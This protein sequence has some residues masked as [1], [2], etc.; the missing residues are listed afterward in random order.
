MIRRLHI[1]NFKAWRDTKSLKFA[2][3][4]VLFGAN[5]SGKSSINHLLMMLRQTVRST[6]RNSVL[7]LGDPESPVQLG[8][9][10][11]LL[12]EHDMARELQ[13]SIEWTLPTQMT[14]RDPHS[15]NRYAGNAIRFD[16]AMRQ[17]PGGRTLQSQGFTYQLLQDEDLS[18]GITFERDAKRSDRWRINDKNYK[19][20]RT[21]GRAWELPKPVQFYGF[22]NEASVYFQNSAFLADL[23]LAFEGLLEGMSY[24]GPLRDPPARLYLWSGTIPED[25]GWRGESTVQAILAGASRRFNWRAKART[26]SLEQVVGSWLSRLNLAASFEVAEIAPERSE[27]EVRLRSTKRQPEVKLT[28]VGFGV[29]QVLPVISQAFYAPPNSTV[30]MEQPEMHLHPKA[31]SELG[32]LLIEAVTARE[33]SAPRGVQLIVESHS[34]HLLRRIQRHIAEEHISAD[35]VALFF[36]YAGR[37][38]SGSVIERLELDEYGDILNWPPEFFG[39]ELQDLVAQTE[40]GMQRRFKLS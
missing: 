5:S 15:Q 19:L 20:V 23:E 31:Q 18:V 12:F 10:R 26:R 6:D 35:D 7:D 37:P 30:L 22:P 38:G 17:A 21:P 9:F 39:D 32:D 36:C 8:T 2:P 16:G 24:L 33:N 4:T 13:L 25:V 34:E 40:I 14:I 27:Y 11:D 29:S 28:D 1:K 3:L